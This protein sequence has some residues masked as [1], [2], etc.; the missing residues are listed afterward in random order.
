LIWLIL[1][2][3]LCFAFLFSGIGSALLNVSRVRARHAAEEGDHSAV[4]LAQLLEHRNELHHAVTVLHHL[5]ALAAFACCVMA[6]VGRFG[7]WGW[8]AAVALALPLFLLGLE[9]VPKLL[10]RRY[11]F[12]LLRRLAGPLEF[13][14]MLARPW[15]WLAQFVSR[16]SNGGSANHDDSLGVQALADTVT[17]LGVLP[18]SI[19]A[20][21]LRAA[22]FQ[23]LRAKNLAM[24]LADLIALPPDMPLTSAIALNA[25]PQHPW[26][27]V[28]GPEGHLLGWLDMTGLPARPS[29]DKLVRQFMRPLLQV[30]AEDGAMRCLQSLR[31]RSE[32]VAA[33]LDEGRDAVGVLIQQDL[34]A[35]VFK[36]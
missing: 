23:K 33:V 27:A 19:C 36:A 24:P 26:R 11:P 17:T 9:L 31:K 1:A 34:I 7:N 18:P 15:I 5:F 6:L 30:R 3:C 14:R 25:Q 8:F 32:P 4:R 20:L 22:A 21:V 29:S 10:F 16:R 35:S 2:V 12:R 13:L 28:L